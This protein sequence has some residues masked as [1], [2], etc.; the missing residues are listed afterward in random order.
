MPDTP[1][2]APEQLDADRVAHLAG[3]ARIALT[4]AE[5]ERLA[6]Q[7]S[8]VLE[9]VAQVQ[10]VATPDVPATSHPMPLSNVTREDVPVPGLGA[11]AAL[12]GAPAVEDDRFRVPRILEED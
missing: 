12:A 9:A 4:D 1:A 10:E 5:R 7:L 8:V 6:G 3:L 2:R 11:E